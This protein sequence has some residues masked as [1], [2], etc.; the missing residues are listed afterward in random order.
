MSASSDTSD[1][2]TLLTDDLLD[3]DSEDFAWK[4]M[5]HEDHYIDLRFSDGK[6][7]S[8][9][10]FAV[11][12]AQSSVFIARLE[13]LREPTCEVRGTFKGWCLVLELVNKSDPPKA[14]YTLQHIAEA[15]E[16]AKYYEMHLAETALIVLAM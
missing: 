16:I 11:L 12:K 2:P 9:V 15:L 7:L 14:V 6:V 4:H 3:S 13:K 5:Q 1:T 10:N 8:K